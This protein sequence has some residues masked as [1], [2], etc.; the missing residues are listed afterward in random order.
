[1]S[2]QLPVP[3]RAALTAL[4][5]VLLGTSCGIA[6]IAEDRRR[7]INRA[8]M[9]IENGER[10]RSARGYRAG[11]DLQI[12]RRER[13]A[14]SDNMPLADY[15][16][17][18]GQ[19]TYHPRRAK[20][21]LSTS[22]RDETSESIPHAPAK[23]DSLD[24][25]ALKVMVQEHTS[26]APSRWPDAEQSPASV[27]RTPTDSQTEL[28]VSGGS[29]YRNGLLSNKEF[30]TMLQQD[31][32]QTPLQIP[33]HTAEARNHATVDHPAPRSQQIP[34]PFIPPLPGIATTHLGAGTWPSTKADANKPWVAT[35]DES[36]IIM[37]SLRDA[38]RDRDIKALAR[39]VQS[40]HGAFQNTKEWVETYALLCR[41][42]VEMGRIS[43]ALEVFH[44]VNVFHFVHRSQELVS[45]DSLAEQIA[46]FEPLTLA[47]LSLAEAKYHPPRSPEHLKHLRGALECYLAIPRAMQQDARLYGVGRTLVFAMIEVDMFLKVR[48]V[49]RRATEHV[50]DDPDGFTAQFLTKLLEKHRH[51]LAIS[52]FLDF[53]PRLSPARESIQAIGDTLVQCVE[54]AHNWRA[55]AVMKTLF[56]MLPPVYK[57][58]TEWVA[59][60]F[61][62]DWASHREFDITEDL[63]E[64]LTTSHLE[65]R[66]KEDERRKLEDVVLHPDCIYRIMI[67]IALQAGEG[68]KAEK[69]LDAGAAYKP[70]IATDVQLLGIFARDCAKRGDWAEVR[71]M[72]KTMKVDG[73]T[74]TAAYGKAFVPV[75]KI[76]AREHSTRETEAFVR[77]YLDELKVP[78]SPFLVTFMAKQ[79]ALVRD[80][81]G[82]AEWLEYC[83]RDG[84][85]VDAAFT[86]AILVAC[87]R[88]GNMPFRELRTLFRKLRSLSP[89][90]V[91]THTERIMA[92]AALA[93][94]Q[95]RGKLA[96][97]R[98][99]S[100]RVAPN[101]R[102]VQGLCARDHDVVLSMQEAIVTHHPS[103]AIRVYKQAM[104]LGMPPSNRALHLAVQAAWDMPVPG[105]DTRVMDLL[106]FARRYGQDINYVTNYIISL[107]LKEMEYEGERQDKY[108][109]AKSVLELFEKK[110][111]SLADVSFNRAANLCLKAGHLMGAI[112]FAHKAVEVRTGA[113][114]CYNMHNFRILLSAYVELV[115][116]ERIRDVIAKV[117]LADYAEQT[118]CLKTLKNASRRVLK[119]ELPRAS[120]EQRREARDIIRNGV[121]K[122]VEAR[123]RLRANV[124]EMQ[125]KA[126]DIMRRA[127][128]D[129]GCPPVDFDTIPWLGGGK[130]KGTEGGEQEP[131]VADHDVDHNDYL[132]RLETI[133]TA[134]AGPG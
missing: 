82:V 107:R 98:L 77:S 35:D 112:L 89:E 100:L 83:S 30:K 111:I 39:A 8:L 121:L 91:D 129:A 33:R 118:G 13:D 12:A 85:P 64:S 76:Y 29:I 96:A 41:T 2:S 108:Q 43:D 75:A 93:D 134:T 22:L 10:I 40:S 124:E 52:T 6:L 113:Q 110:G 18:G 20:R 102:P 78:M 50:I 44:S 131:E 123:E 54:E 84:F 59:K 4:R 46:L 27:G 47:E 63:F 25:G 23:D 56:R 92:N 80:F 1:M 119:V 70:D 31:S 66:S 115:D 60:L 126:L 79:Y 7:R 81:S 48:V 125:S 127:A 67:E 58:K 9:V 36:G 68:A 11:G 5:G 120:D 94:P 17:E 74:S 109:K 21:R 122:I 15:L 53:F 103:R 133:G 114:P 116:V 57:I 37:A 106:Q 73:P 49:F 130:G 28:P 99:L 69:Y 16:Q 87:R 86:N 90:Y 71:R 45:A 14:F 61:L 128:I 97:G 24:H 62:A 95:E 55:S 42:Y 34:V 26:S 88:E 132:E 65:D 51:R 72:F 3:S 105:R 19:H 38:C 104:R 101:L 32:L 117:V